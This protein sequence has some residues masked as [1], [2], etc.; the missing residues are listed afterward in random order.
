MRPT[1]SDSDA[2]PEIPLTGGRLTDGVV[3]VG[4]TVRR[5]TG[6]HSPFVHALLSR[7]EAVGFDGAPRLLGIDD[8]GREILSFLDGW[9]PPNLARFPDETLIAAA[10]LLRRFHDATAGS[11]LAGDHEVVCHNDPSPCNAVFAGWRPVA[12]IDFDHAAPGDRMSDLAYAGWLW[13]LT[14]DDD[15][16]PIAEQARRLRLMAESYGLPDLTGLLDA[17][18]RRQ[19]ENLA[20]TLARTR[21][22]DASVV[23]YAQTAAA[24]QRRQMTWLRANAAT[25]RAAL[26]SDPA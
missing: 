19:E 14:A 21:A 2:G 18:L 15:G 4:E 6:P 10:R 16:P 24:W 13:T 23:E 22:R 9:V 17:V 8:R 1:W 5:P 7:L 12:L 25:F 11:M 3:R 20:Q 26:A